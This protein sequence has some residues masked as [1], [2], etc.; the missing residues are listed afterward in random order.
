[1][2]LNYYFQYVEFFIER[3]VLGTSRELQKIVMEYKGEP[4]SPGTAIKW[5]S[6]KKMILPVCPPTLVGVCRLIQIYYVLKVQ[7]IEKKN[8]KLQITIAKILMFQVSIQ[9][10]KS[11][12]D[13]QMHF[14]ITVAT[15]PFRIPNLTQQPQIKYGTR[16]EK[17]RVF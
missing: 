11:G 7:I 16:V 17:I 13:M 6:S 3:G 15:V 9:L 4:V 5:D 2:T 10:E 8:Q 12:E 1:M 14:P